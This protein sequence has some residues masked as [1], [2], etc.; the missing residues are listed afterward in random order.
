MGIGTQAVHLLP[1]DVPIPVIQV[2]LVEVELSAL[3]RTKERRLEEGTPTAPVV[4]VVQL[5]APSPLPVEVEVIGAREIALVGDPPSGRTP[6]G[7][8]A[9]RVTW[10]DPYNPGAPPFLLDDALGR[11]EWITI[12]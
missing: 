1:A 8:S 3:G 12:N 7:G 6:P 5:G 4:G 10:F 9:Y 11:K 2:P